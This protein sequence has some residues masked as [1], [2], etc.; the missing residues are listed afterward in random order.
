[1]VGASAPNG[2]ATGAGSATSSAGPA[3]DAFKT[4]ESGS[5]NG[6]DAS[7]GVETPS[8]TAS[9]W[10]SV[11]ALSNLSLANRAVARA[12]HASNAGGSAIPRRAA[13][14]V[15]GSSAPAIT[16]PRKA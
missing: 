10:A 2:P 1:M 9:S 11:E 4:R 3:S 12:N 13:R 15:G 7:L 14:T 8:T 5:R 16:F 6:N